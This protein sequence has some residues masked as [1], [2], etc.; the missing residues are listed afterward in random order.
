VSQG[1]RI[2]LQILLHQMNLA[3]LRVSSNMRPQR[4]GTAL[5]WAVLFI[6]SVVLFS[7][8]A[9]NSPTTCPTDKPLET[10]TDCTQ[11][12]TFWNGVR[13][14]GQ[15]RDGRP[16]GEGRFEFSNGNVYEGSFRDGV[17]NGFGVFSYTN[18]NRYVGEWLEERAH[19]RGLFTF[20]DGRPPLEGIWRRDEFV[21]AEKIPDIL[22]GRASKADSKSGGGQPEKTARKDPALSEI[23][24]LS[25]VV[26]EPDADGHVTLIINANTS[27]TSL[28]MGDMELGAR[29]DGRYTAKKFVQVG[30]NTIEI[31]AT[32][33]NGAVQRQSV[34]V[35]RIVRD[36][37]AVVTPLTPTRVPAAT[38]RD[39][40]AI[41]I[42][43]EKYR[44]VPSAEF[45]NRDASVFYDYAR[46]ALGVPSENIRLLLDDQADAAEVLRSFKSWLPTRVTEDKTEVYV[47]YSGHGLPSEDGINL[48]F[49]PHEVDRD[50]LERTAVTQEDIVSAIDR[51]KPK[52]VTM[53]IDSCYSGQSRTGEALLAS[54]RPLAVATKGAARFPSNFTVISASAPDQISS[55][56]AE[57]RH[58][59]FSYYLMR[60]MEGDADQDKD[61]RITVAEMQ[62]YLSVR[63]GRRAMTMNRTQS[64]QVTGDQTRI[65]VGK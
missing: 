51:L 53:F 56:S 26:S 36:Q 28:K 22:A 41:I 61:G 44:R 10:W 42:G 50:F 38:P 62:A 40:V 25:V 31:I 35:S 13:F 65:L 49:L 4:S 15:F 2:I 39:A 47:F 55:S 8:Q 34:A 48:Y 11:D 16:N 6:S 27:T 52:S 54:A 59:I 58:G 30:E 24:R 18:G 29:S 19:G 21:R 57:L 43:I 46:R 14:T 37:A 33:R 23:P 60:G 64:P 5:L 20:G 3:H 17:P 63:V 45:A 9:A 32:D 1:L 7:A 12:V